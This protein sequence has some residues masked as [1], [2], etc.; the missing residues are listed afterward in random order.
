MRVAGIRGAKRRGKPWRTTKADPGAKRRPDL[1]ERDF[2]A[3][4]PDRLWVADLSYLRC[5]EGVLYFAFIIDVFSRMVVGWQIAFHMRTTLVL[6]ALRMALCARSPGAE[7]ALVHHS[8]RGSQYTSAD[9]G[10]ALDD[11]GVLASLGSTGD[12]Y[13]NALAESFVD[14]CKTELIADRV[15]RTR[16]QLELALVA[17]LGWFNHVRLHS[18][19]AYLPPA[20][21]ERRYLEQLAR[22]Q[23]G[24]LDGNESVAAPSPRASDRPR[25][26]PISLSSVNS[27]TETGRSA[28]SSAT[29][30]QAGGAQAAS[31]AGGRDAG[32]HVA[33]LPMQC[34]ATHT[35]K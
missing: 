23:N 5:W 3:A 27:P 6:D 28:A 10:Q 2:Q 12:C 22:P 34:S 29:V 13:D 16:S 21:Y 30:A 9:Y 7:V 4:G 20:E 14:S 24:P 31:R 25:I 17:Y 15:W 32:L 18:A 8:D 1:V 26:P 33:S 11:H 19:L 35:H